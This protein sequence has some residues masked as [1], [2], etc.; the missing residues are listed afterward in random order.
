MDEI[1]KDIKDYEGLYMISNLGRIKS[2]SR[3]RNESQP[4]YITKEKILKPQKMGNGYL[5]VSL[6][7][8]KKCCNKAIHTLVAKAFI[9]NPLNLPEV[10]HKDGNKHNNNVTNLEWCTDSYN[11]LHAFKTGLM[12]AVKGENH[13][14]HKLTDL[15]VKEIRELKGKLT[16]Q[17]IA[18]IYNVKQGIIS[19]IHLN[20]NWKH[21]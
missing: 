3:Q 16:Q 9:P 13:G 11:K 10:N 14:N 6:Y 19:C 21:I 8:K 4:N 17:K 12:N 2:L 20:K 5:R 15:Q 7:K 18:D 1:W